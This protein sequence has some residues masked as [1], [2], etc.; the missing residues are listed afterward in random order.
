MDKIFTTALV[1][2]LFIAS[3][4]NAQSYNS[5]V[6]SLMHNVN[7]DT[8]VSYVR[9]LSGEDSVI[10]NNTRVLIG[11]RVNTYEDDLA[12]DFIKIKLNS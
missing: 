2:L 11:R 12:A 9:I 8:L 6:D 7:I 3:V 10:I 1:I 4:M 5:V